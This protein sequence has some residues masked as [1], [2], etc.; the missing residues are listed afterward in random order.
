MVAA[1]S[2]KMAALSRSI[3]PESLAG[4]TAMTS[5]WTEHGIGQP[6][7]FDAGGDCF[8]VGKCAMSFTIA[9]QMSALRGT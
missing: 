9:G 8:F 6:L 4:L 1:C 2:V 5:M 3:R 7:D